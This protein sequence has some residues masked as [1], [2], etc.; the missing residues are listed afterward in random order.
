MD[1]SPK[2]FL[3]KRRPNKFSDSIVDKKSNLNR[4]TLESYLINLTS[5]NEQ[6]IFEQFIVSLCEL[7]ICP[8]IKP[9]TGPAGG[10]DG[11]TDAE[12]Y[13]VS[14]DT[15]QGWYIGYDTAK[16]DQSLAFAISAKKAWE[17]KLNHDLE[18]IYKT[19]R[20]FTQTYFVTN[21]YVKAD[22][23]KKLEKE[24]GDKYKTDLH[25]LDLTWI[26]RRVF[27][28][29]RI[30]LAIQK[31]GIEGAT[32]DVMDLG[33]NDV[34][35]RKKI[36]QLDAE[37]ELEN[38]KQA[39]N[40]T[41]VRDA[42]DVAV[43][44]REQELPRIEVEGRLERAIRLAD[45]YGTTNQRF[46]AR[47]QKCWTAFWYFEDV[48]VLKDCYSDAERHALK[49]AGISNLEK[50]SNLH[51]ILMTAMDRTSGVIS[52]A[53]FDSKTKVLLSELKKIAANKEAP[54]SS[55][56][57]RALLAQVSMTNAVC[58]H[59]SVEEALDEF[60][61]I[62]DESE[63]MS[64][65]PFDAVTEL[66]SIM[67]GVIGDSDKY[68]AVFTKVRQQAAK[69]DGEKRS[70]EMVLERA[71][72][73]LIEEKS[74]KAIQLLGSSL[75]SFQKEETQDE[76]SEAFLLMGIAY[77]N[78]GLLWAAR[79]SYLNGASIETT[80]FHKDDE[81]SPTQIELYRSLVNIELRL[82]R[83][84]QFLQWLEVLE[85]F[86]SILPAD[87]WNVE[88]LE[89]ERLFCDLRLGAT[90]LTCN[91]D[92]MHLSR[93]LPIIER[94]GLDNSV[95]ALNYRIGREDLYSSEFTDV[96]P[97]NERRKYMEEWASQAPKNI[98]SDKLLYANTIS[99]QLTAQ[100][101]GCDITVHYENSILNN[102]TAESILACLESILAT[103]FLHRGSSTEP[104]FDIWIRNDGSSGYEI[105]SELD[106]DT[107]AIKVTVPDFNPHSI[108]GEDQGILGESIQKLA[109]KVVSSIVMFAD[110]QKSLEKIF[111]EERAFDRS[112]NFTSS[113]I[114]LGN[115]IGYNP[116]YKL[117]EWSDVADKA[118]EVGAKP[119]IPFP[120]KAEEE[121]DFR[122]FKPEEIGH[123]N[124]STLSVIKTV[125][126]EK[127]GWKG[128]FYS[129]AIGSD[130]LPI[131]AIIFGNPDAGSKIFEGWHE[132]YGDEDTKDSIRIAILRDIDDEY[133]AD[134]R[135][136]ISANMEVADI[137]GKI[138]SSITRIHTMNTESKESLDVFLKQYR[139]V[140]SYYLAAAMFGP[141]GEPML[142]RYKI[143]KKLLV[144][145]T[146][147]EIYDNDPDSV[148]LGKTNRAD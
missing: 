105:Q 24:L 120:K 95:L 61:K 94:V 108:S 100:V 51:S 114:R 19:E 30:S 91:E 71:K 35:R 47:Y 21:Q 73:L 123:N 70:A 107:A 86:I 145:K 4:A 113:Y 139:K 112:I 102:M 27:D 130:E 125:L 60:E 33:P 34:G 58:S 45:K 16:S 8:N 103:A 59:K 141:E 42:I 55:L 13:P 121:R 15:A 146:P 128:A 89:E 96:I 87:E 18:E 116:K 48:Q 97:E 39:V 50:L 53:F 80:R 84:P 67:G 17:P 111:G 65:F 69:R 81:A 131:L 82:G 72:A 14:G 144:V 20:K 36:L 64:G 99:I 98:A 44:S 66:L 142:Y 132:E 43:L 5:R 92:A 88:K 41:T 25:L 75:P 148:L 68:D 137:K 49:A 3:K 129:S 38:S 54:S 6:D 118:V 77:E 79:A 122:Q 46:M 28:N 93:L 74:Y 138:V 134:Y 2:D 127:A 119:S 90:I 11:K 57:A 7:E 32:D 56:F 63:G 76:A 136:G 143:K 40:Y 12:T 106:S 115:V 31:L 78:V 23:R 109:I 62:I 126:W 147:G 22:K 52:K 10:G 26:L 85:V 29:K 83:I 110:T 140:G 117:S 101:L 1:I 135:V 37:I 124:L 104:K 9:N 133:P